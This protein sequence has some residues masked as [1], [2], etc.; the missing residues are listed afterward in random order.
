MDFFSSSFLKFSGS[1]ARRSWIYILGLKF[2]S[3]LILNKL[4]NH[5]WVSIYFPDFQPLRG[6]GGIKYGG[7]EGNSI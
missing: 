1:G 6:V 3:G 5:L 4:L 2:T 7:V